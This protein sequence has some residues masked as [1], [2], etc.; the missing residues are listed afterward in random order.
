MKLALQHKESEADAGHKK[1]V[2]GIVLT[3]EKLK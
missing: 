2:F 3:S 1:R